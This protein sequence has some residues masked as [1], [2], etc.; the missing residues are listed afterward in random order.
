MQVVIV[1]EDGEFIRHLYGYPT[2][3]TGAVHSCNDSQNAIVGPFGPYVMSGFQFI[4]PGWYQVFASGNFNDTQLFVATFQFQ[5]SINPD[6]VAPLTPDDVTDGEYPN[7]VQLLDGNFILYWKIESNSRINVAIVAKTTGWVGIG[8]NPEDDG[9]LNCDMIMGFVDDNTGEVTVNDMYSTGEDVPTEDT[10]YTGE[11]TY[12]ILEKN[13]NQN[14]ERGTTTIKFRRYWVTPDQYDAE[15]QDEI[16]SVVFALNPTTDLMVKHGTENTGLVK[17]NFIT[18]IVEGIDTF[19]ERKDAH[20]AMMAFSWLLFAPMGIFI[21]RFGHK[22]K[23]WFAVHI[24]L[25]VAACLLSIIGLIITKTEITLDNKLFFVHSVVGISIVA[26]GCAIQPIV[27][28]I[29]D[30]MYDPNRTKV[31]VWPDKVHWYIGRYSFVGAFFNC[32]LGMIYY[33]VHYLWFVLYVLD[34]LF[35]IAFYHY[36]DLVFCKKKPTEQQVDDVLELPEKKL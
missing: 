8:F 28:I 34:I 30:Q 21:A 26:C 1:H 17:I 9:M 10:F 24:V 15:I 4:I 19:Q 35:L 7:S 27:G 11:G 31:P 29:S 25:M 20:A 33:E 5:V 23:W 2:E 6:A 36:L 18:G 14:S 16:T 22:H 13:G 32:L 3:G 12:D